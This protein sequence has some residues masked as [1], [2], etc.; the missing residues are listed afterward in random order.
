MVQQTP[1]GPDH[2]D[3]RFFLGKL[4]SKVD[5]VLANQGNLAADIKDLTTRI[6]AVESDLTR[7]QAERSTSGRLASG[8]WT[9]VTAG[10]A[11]AVSVGSALAALFSRNP[12]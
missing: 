2:G 1:D 8:A 7:L 4:D 9:V 12:T 5:Q 3:L 6:Q 11:L 10:T